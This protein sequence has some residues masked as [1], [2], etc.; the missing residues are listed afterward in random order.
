MISVPGYTPMM[1][2][3]AATASLILFGQGIIGSYVWRANENAKARPL[4]VVQ[5]QYKFHPEPNKQSLTSE[6]TKPSQPASTLESD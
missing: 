2:L 6:Q 1:L 4:S 3:L 5:S